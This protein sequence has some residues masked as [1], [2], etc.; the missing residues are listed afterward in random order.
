MHAR[1]LRAAFTP[2]SSSTN[3]RARAK[4]IHARR[5]PLLSG[6]GVA[7][8]GA[9]LRVVAALL[10]EWAGSWFARLAWLNLLLGAFNL[11]P[12]L[13][14]D[15]GRVLRAL[16][17]RNHD[18]KTATRMAGRVARVLAVVMAVV[19]VLYDYWLVIIAIFVWLG[20][21]GE[22]SAAEGLGGD[23]KG[24]RSSEQRDS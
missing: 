18:Q 9:T 20:A 23:D 22:E 2:G 7:P 13:P 14:M 4:P 12:A 19:G 24:G 15:G 1:R 11:L 16:L 10:C 6:L 3:K 21:R 5:T 8:V 17:A